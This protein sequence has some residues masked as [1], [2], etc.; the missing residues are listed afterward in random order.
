MIAQNDS[1]KNQQEPILGYYHLG[2]DFDEYWS[3]SQKLKETTEIMDSTTLMTEYLI[4]INGIAFDVNKFIPLAP[5]S[6]LLTMKTTQRVRY[7]FSSQGITISL[8]TN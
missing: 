5:T 1:I 7:H 6:R 4:S 8:K 2:M 3:Q